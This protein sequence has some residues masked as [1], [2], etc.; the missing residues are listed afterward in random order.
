MKEMARRS[1]ISPRLSKLLNRVAGNLEKLRRS[2]GW[3]QAEA[4]ERIEGDLRWYQRL[5]SGKHVLSLDTLVRLSQAF[6]VDVSEFFR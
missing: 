4:A 3:T 5:E 2:K 1:E 6:K